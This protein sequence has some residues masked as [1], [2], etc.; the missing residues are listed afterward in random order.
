MGQQCAFDA[1]TIEVAKSRFWLRRKRQHA[2]G[3]AIAHRPAA[4]VS[5][6]QLKCEPLRD[7]RCNDQKIR[8]HAERDSLHHHVDENPDGECR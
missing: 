1:A 2:I 4:L 6:A 5:R 3:G 8:T 7:G